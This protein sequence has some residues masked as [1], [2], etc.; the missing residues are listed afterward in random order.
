VAVPEF[1]S[2]PVHV[3]VHDAGGHVVPPLRAREPRYPN[4]VDVM[5]FLHSGDEPFSM[6]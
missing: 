4:F 5:P 3:V 6:G 2:Q 1:V